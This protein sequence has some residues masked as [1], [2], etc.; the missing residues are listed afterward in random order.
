S[1]AAGARPA[2]GGAL[3]ATARARSEHLAER[4]GR[5]ADTDVERPEQRESR[6]RRIEAHLV[7]QL[8][9]DQRVVG[10]Q[11]HPP[12]PV[13]EPDGALDHLHHPTGVATSDLALPAHE[14]AAFR[15]RQVVPV[16]LLPAALRHGVEA[17]VAGRGNRRIQPRARELLHLGT[18]CRVEVLRAR[19]DPA[20]LEDCR[21]VG[22]E[23]VGAELDHREVRVARHQERAQARAVERRLLTAERLEIRPPVHEAEV[24]LLGQQGIAGAVTIRRLPLEDCD[25]L[26]RDGVPLL[27]AERV[28][29]APVHGVHVV[30]RVPALEGDRRFRHGPLIARRPERLKLRAPAA[31]SEP[32]MQ[33]GSW[34]STLVFLPVFG[35]VMVVFDVA[36][37]IARLF[38]QRPQEY[39]AGA[40]QWALVHTFGLCD[41][42]LA[43]ERS[44][45]VL[46]WTSYIIVSNHQSMF[47]IPI[48]GSLFF[49]NLPK[50]ISKRSL[51][52]WIPSVSYNLRRGGHVL[53]DRSDAPA[54]LE[55]IRALGRRVR[56]GDVS[57]MIFPEGTRARVGEL[58]P[59]K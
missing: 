17:Q 37:R 56:N 59:F 9:E 51:G 50:Y 22:G 41:T 48:L 46:P 29:A 6:A 4:S 5:E 18:Q 3:A 38:G 15:G 54:A 8:L 12:L 45:D 28:P 44:P 27:G 16:D 10:E 24:A 26:A 40:L 55:A 43:V 23:L 52:R 39:V 34:L 49:S 53:I 25:G 31:Y 2:G 20:A 33:L 42:R 47:D 32:G 30:Q 11:R 14:R 36:Q 21:G 35:L 13:V 57:A 58:A 7:D 1:P 19:G